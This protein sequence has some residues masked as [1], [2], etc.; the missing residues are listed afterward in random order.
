[1]TDNEHALMLMMFA[2]QF[3]YIKT[4]ENMLISN[5]VIQADDP[6][7]FD[8]ASLSDP[9]AIAPGFR[10]TEEQYRQFAESVGLILP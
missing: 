4:L 9:D 10:E 7:L 6:A 3:Q 8:A 1:M 2:R 5:G